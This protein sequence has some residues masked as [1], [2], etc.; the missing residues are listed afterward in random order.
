MPQPRLSYIELLPRTIVFCESGWR[1]KSVNL[2]P[3]GFG[4]VRSAS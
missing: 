2:L 1:Q 4:V 3:G